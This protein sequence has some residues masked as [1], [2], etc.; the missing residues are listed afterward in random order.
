MRKETLQAWAL[1]LPGAACCWWLSRT[2]PPWRRWWTALFSTPHGSR[3]SRFVGLDNYA[4]LLDDPVFWRAMRN[5]AI[6][7]AVT[8]PVSIVLALLMALAVN[9]RSARRG[10]CC[11]WRISRRPC[12][13]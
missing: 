9:T 10:R 6:Y 11:A 5:N 3:P 12:C 7:A 4:G 13:R 2:G 1:I 8:I